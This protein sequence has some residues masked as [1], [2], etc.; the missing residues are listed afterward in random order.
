MS[1]YYVL[2]CIPASFSIL[3]MLLMHFY[4]SFPYAI[5]NILLSFL[6]YLKFCFYFLN[7]S[8]SRNPLTTFYICIADCT[9]L[10]LSCSLSLALCLRSSNSF[11]LLFSCSF[12][13]FSISCLSTSIGL[14]DLLLC[15]IMSFF[16]KNGYGYS[17]VL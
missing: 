16:A 9:L 4:L 10:I 14:G 12:F 2:T 15:S 7:L 11:F 13:L 3:I 6:M 5:D 1:S 8:L 17:M